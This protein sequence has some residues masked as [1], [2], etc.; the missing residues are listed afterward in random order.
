[1]LHTPTPTATCPAA[2]SSLLRCSLLLATAAAAFTLGVAGCSS[3][4]HPASNS[5][6]AAPPLHTSVTGMPVGHVQLQTTDGT[7]A[8]TA[9]LHSV[10]GG[11]EI[12]LQVQG[13][14]PGTHGFHIHE[15]GE[16]GPSTDANGKT[17]DFGAAGGHFD[18]Y[19]TKTHGHPGQSPQQ[20]HAGDTPNLVVDTHGRGSLRYTNTGVSLTPGTTSIAGLSLVVHESQDDYQ[21]NPAGNSGQRIACGVIR[22]TPGNRADAG[23]ALPARAQGS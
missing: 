22:I 1:M 14:A 8:G 6:P 21:T 19:H 4:Q 13:M 23:S 3:A 10:Q 7:A 17:V 5:H 16:C 18:P 9:T 2:S 12:F 15:K 11:V 20:V